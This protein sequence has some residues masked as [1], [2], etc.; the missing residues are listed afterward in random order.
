MIKLNIC[1]KI[2]LTTG[3]IIAITSAAGP[4]KASP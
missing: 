1:R 2:L 4:K 3:F